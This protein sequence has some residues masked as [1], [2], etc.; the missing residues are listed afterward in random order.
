M[1]EFQI[2]N[3]IR[4][5][6]SH[7]GPLIFLSDAALPSIIAETVRNISTSPLDNDLGNK[8]LAP[9]HNFLKNMPNTLFPCGFGVPARHSS[10]SVE[11]SSLNGVARCSNTVKQIIIHYNNKYHIMKQAHHIPFKVDLD[12]GYTFPIFSPNTDCLLF[13]EKK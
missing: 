11:R 9:A 10:P 1:I 5:L 7:L 3:S 2:E 4:T 8:K 6:K 13:Y 12:Q